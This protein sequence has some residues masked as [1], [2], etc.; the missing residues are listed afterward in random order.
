VLEMV[1]DTCRSDGNAW[2]A[3]F[4]RLLSSGS[5]IFKSTMMREYCR[6]Y[7]IPRALA[8]NLSPPPLLLAVQRL[9]LRRRVLCRGVACRIASCR[10][11][12]ADPSSRVVDRSDPAV[13]ALR[14]V[15]G[16][17]LG[18]VRHRGIREFAG[19]GAASRI[20]HGSLRP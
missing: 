5:L 13:G 17:L 19:T 10:E 11:D 16:G 12:S 7:L 15:P 2:S 18:P 20:L 14:P 4:Q 6:R 3:R 1:A 8:I 9:C